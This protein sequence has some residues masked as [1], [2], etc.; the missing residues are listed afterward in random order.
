MEQLRLSGPA[1]LHH[2]NAFSDQLFEAIPA[3]GRKD[4]ESPIAPGTAIAGS[5]EPVLAPETARENFCVIVATVTKMDWLKLERGGHRR[6]VF[7]YESGKVAA[8]WVHP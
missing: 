6:A 2:K 1:Q 5:T 8:N 7:T 3:A 4:Y